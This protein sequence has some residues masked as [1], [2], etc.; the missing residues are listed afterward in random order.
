MD[1]NL[2]RDQNNLSAFITKTEEVLQYVVKCRIVLFRRELRKPIKDAWQ[3]LQKWERADSLKIKSIFQLVKEQLIDPDWDKVKI[4][5]L[6]DEQ[7]HLKLECFIFAYNEFK[8]WGTIKLLKKVLDWI[9]IVLDSLKT[10][11]PI[12]E[13]ISEFKKVC[14][15]GIDEEGGRIVPESKFQNLTD[16][17]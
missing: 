2:Q 11:V 9:N 3:G 13:P 12:I 6:V 16:D 4:A 1:T 8:Q 14:E 10:A 5:G 7:L 17:S 15:A